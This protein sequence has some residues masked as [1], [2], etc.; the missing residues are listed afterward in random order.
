MKKILLTGLIFVSLAGCKKDKDTEPDLAARAAG[1]YT[2]SK[3]TYAGTN[4]P[5]V[6]GTELVIVI[7]KATAESVTGAMKYKLEGKAQP[8]EP[9]GTLTVKDA[10]SSG[11]DF[12][13]GSARVGNLSKDNLLTVSGSADGLYF[14]IIAQ[15]Q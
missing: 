4:I 2:A 3:F 5:L 13:E 11:I 1:T 14:E 12:Y 10:G 9:L 6:G 7:Q 8:D 15:K